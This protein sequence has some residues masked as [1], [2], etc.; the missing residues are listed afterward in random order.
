MKI[1]NV[2]LWDR[3]F[4]Y[5]ESEHVIASVL[6]PKGIAYIDAANN[7]EELWDKFV[8]GKSYNDIIFNGGGDE[9]IKHLKAFGYEIIEPT[10]ASIRAPE[11]T[12]KEWEELGL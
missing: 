8:E 4:E 10:T 11:Q 12:E 5:N 7:I 1:I 6:P 3:D 9:F 2:T